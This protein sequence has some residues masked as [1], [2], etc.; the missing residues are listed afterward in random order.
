MVDYL[1]RVVQKTDSVADIS[2]RLF[3]N[4][5]RPTFA[6]VVLLGSNYMIKIVTISQF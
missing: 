5:K 2:H 4:S 3:M 1:K 6:S